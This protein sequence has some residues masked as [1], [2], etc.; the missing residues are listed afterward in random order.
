MIKMLSVTHDTG[1]WANHNQGEM[2]WEPF[3]ADHG[4]G[5]PDEPA[6][7]AVRKKFFAQLLKP[8]SPCGVVDG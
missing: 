7:V 6:I 3:S 5:G 4:T 2:G 8:R 1:R